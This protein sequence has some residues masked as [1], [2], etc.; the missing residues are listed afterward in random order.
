MTA[1]TNSVNT[2]ERDRATGDL[3]ASEVRRV[4]AE[5]LQ[6]WEVAQLARAAHGL[7][8]AADVIADLKRGQRGYAGRGTYWETTRKGVQVRL[9]DPSVPAG[10]RTGLITWR[11]M[12]LVVAD[13]ATPDRLAALNQ[14]LRDKKPTVARR[15]AKAIVTAGPAVSQLD[16]LDQLDELD[17]PGSIEDGDAGT[18]AGGQ[19]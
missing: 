13:G 10:Y 19:S 9:P 14:A 11:L 16:L 6:A 1:A 12:R 3:T 18:G 5:Y 8:V 15:A 4:L 2:T 17:S 7:T